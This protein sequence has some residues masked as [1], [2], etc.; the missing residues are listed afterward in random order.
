MAKNHEESAEEQHRRRGAEEPEDTNCR[1]GN[2]QE[3][4]ARIR[5]AVR[6]RRGQLEK[7]KGLGEGGRK[8]DGLDSIL[9][10]RWEG[11]RRAYKLHNTA[12]TIVVDS[13]CMDRGLANETV[14]TIDCRIG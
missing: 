2:S 1:G 13:P 9:L 12:T 14:R 11:V 3:R 6:L 4:P 5:W 10:D 7:L 8:P